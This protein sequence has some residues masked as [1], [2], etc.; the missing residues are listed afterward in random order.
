MSIL[1]FLDYLAIAVF[2][3]TG[4]LSAS[5]KQLD[6]VGFIFL[7]ALT[8]I[9]GGTFRDVIL[10]QLPVFWVRNPNY[11][12]VCL[13]S[14]ILVYFTAHLLESRYKLLLWLDAIG[15]SA[16]AALGAAKGLAATGSPVV[17]IVTGMLTSAFGGVLRD[18]VAGEPSVLLRPEIYVSAALAG[19]AVFTGAYSLGFGQLACFAAA[20][21]TCLLIRGGALIFGWTFPVY[22][23]RPGRNPNDIL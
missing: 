9:G 6:I 13:G 17:A 8:G 14:G 21:A 19:A 18:I 23:A 4:A 12:L 11:M 1:E 5:R 16:Y 15:L 20:M 2:A 22:K 3:A 10:G 7:A